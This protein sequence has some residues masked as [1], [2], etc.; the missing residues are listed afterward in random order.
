M[1]FD[2]L[3]EA[4]GLTVGWRSASSGSRPFSSKLCVSGLFLSLTLNQK[5]M[6]SDSN[7]FREL[8]MCRGV[9]YSSRVRERA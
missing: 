4:S 6:R 7:E 5:G 9:K 2:S 1:V 3:P 8:T